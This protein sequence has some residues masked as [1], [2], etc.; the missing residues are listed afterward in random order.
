MRPRRVIPSRVVLALVALTLASCV[1]KSGTPVAFAPSTFHEAAPAGSFKRGERVRGESCEKALVFIE[2]NGAPLGIRLDDSAVP[3]DI[4]IALADAQAKCKDCSFLAN[5]TVDTE[6]RSQCL[7]LLV[8]ECTIVKGTAM[9]ALP[10][11]APTVPAVAP[12]Y[13]E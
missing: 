3:R 11:V 7:G 12:A 6:H 1:T 10:A 5:V 4:D 13:P 9:F 2:M 8:E